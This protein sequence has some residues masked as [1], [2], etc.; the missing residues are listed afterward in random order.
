[1]IQK[2]KLSLRSFVVSSI[3]VLSFPLSLPQSRQIIL[4]PDPAFSAPI[5]RTELEQTRQ[6]LNRRLQAL[7]VPGRPRTIIKDEAII[8]TIPNALEPGDIIPELTQINELALIETGVEFPTL[9][10]TTCVRADPVADPD[11]NVYHLLLSS[12]DFIRARPL[13]TAAGD[14][15][16]DITLTPAGA[17]RFAGF[18]SDRRG[19]YLCL[20][21]NSIIVGCPIVRLANNNHLEIRQGPV[22]FLVDDQ[23]LINQINAGLFPV[24]LKVSPVN[25]P[26]ISHRVSQ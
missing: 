4:I 24:P 2:W 9:D 16:L 15:G 10:A 25:N 11:R 21:Q 1:M 14:F 18:I 20:T 5:T 13:S 3:I 23:V 26:P 19:V 17:A 8:V 7:A 22:D 12:A 6:I